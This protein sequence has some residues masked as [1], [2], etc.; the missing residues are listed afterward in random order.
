MQSVR[1]KE[2]K[3]FETAKDKFGI[4]NQ[5]AS[6]R[7]LKVVVNTGTGKATRKDKKINE[8]IRRML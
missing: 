8:L 3:F 5:M 6:P 1:E 2:K 4:K 7:V